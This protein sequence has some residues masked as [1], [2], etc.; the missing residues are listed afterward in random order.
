MHYTT[1]EVS[2]LLIQEKIEGPTSNRPFYGMQKI[3]APKTLLLFLF[4]RCHSVSPPF[5][6]ADIRD[7]TLL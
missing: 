7:I 2:L 5:N 6:P 1:T 3:F 4:F